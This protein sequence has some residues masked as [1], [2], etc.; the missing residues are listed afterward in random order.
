MATPVSIEAMGGNGGVFGNVLDPENFAKQHMGSTRR[1]EPEQKMEKGCQVVG[2]FEVGLIPGSLVFTAYSP[3]HNFNTEGVDMAHRVSSLRFSST[4]DSDAREV[5]FFTDMAAKFMGGSTQ[6]KVDPMKD[7]AF[8]ALTG[9]KYSHE[10][11]LRLMQ[12]EVEFD[13]LPPFLAS[14]LPRKHLFYNFLS[15]YQYAVNSHQLEIDGEGAQAQLPSVRF[16]WDMDSL[17][18][19][20]KKTRKSWYTVITS[21][22]AVIGGLFTVLSLTDSVLYSTAAKLFSKR[23]GSAY[24]QAT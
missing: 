12:T 13:T 24:T 11:F 9:H 21:L 14:K 20:F 18:V 22:L 8:A 3:W 1:H 7:R 10:H 23:R 19:R 5:A 15:L 16:V 17:G 4:G 6:L 2:S